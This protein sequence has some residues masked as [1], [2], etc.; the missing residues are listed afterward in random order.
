MIERELVLRDSLPTA[1]KMLNFSSGYRCSGVSAS[2]GSGVSSSMLL[3]Q[4]ASK[5]A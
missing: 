3:S 1:C 5:P 4:R 2:A